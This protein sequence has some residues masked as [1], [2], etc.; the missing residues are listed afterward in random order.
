MPLTKQVHHLYILLLKKGAAEIVKLLINNKAN[1]HQNNLG[2]I[3]VQCAFA[4]GDLETLQLFN[5]KEIDQ[6]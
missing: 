3:P 1:H 2:E 5:M 4:S 6:I